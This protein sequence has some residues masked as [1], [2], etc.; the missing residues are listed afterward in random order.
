MDIKWTSWFFA[1]DHV[2]LGFS[3]IVLKKS[4]K[5]SL[6]WTPVRWP[7]RSLRICMNLPMFS[8]FPPV[9]PSYGPKYQ[10]IPVMAWFI[11]YIRSEN[12]QKIQE[13]VQHFLISPDLFDRVLWKSL[14]EN[15]QKII[16]TRKSPKQITRYIT[17]KNTARFFT[18]SSSCSCRVSRPCPT[19][20]CP[21]P[22]SDERLQSSQVADP[23]P[24]DRLG[25]CGQTREKKG[26]SGDL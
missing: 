4:W 18:N 5:R 23:H 12:H 16:I 26:F 9:S 14:W 8:P 21:L 3:G 22:A 10:W 6:L 25:R 17:H 2:F 11:R 24:D 15:H 13:I 19:A 20:G 7:K 1:T